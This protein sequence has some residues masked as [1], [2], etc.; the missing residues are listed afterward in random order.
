M[1]FHLPYY[2]VS[3]RRGIRFVLHGVSDRALSLSSFLSFF[4]KYLFG[5]TRPLLERE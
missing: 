2:Y 3:P 4:R 1:W 5:I